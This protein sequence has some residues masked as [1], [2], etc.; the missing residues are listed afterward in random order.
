MNDNFKDNF[1]TTCDSM[2][3]DSIL[4]DSIL[5]G[6]RSLTVGVDRFIVDSRFALTERQSLLPGSR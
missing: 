4:S 5:K 6:K 2:S 3:R 1:N